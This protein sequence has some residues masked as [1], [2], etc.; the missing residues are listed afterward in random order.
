V[1]LSDALPDGG[2]FRESALALR[3]RHGLRYGRSSTSSSASLMLWG[4]S[5]V[6]CPMRSP[7][8]RAR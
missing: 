6:T 4:S 1:Q 3:P 8:A 7:S 2:M 5:C